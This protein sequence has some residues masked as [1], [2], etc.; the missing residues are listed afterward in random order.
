MFIFFSFLDS[1]RTAERIDFTV[2][3][4]CVRLFVPS[5]LK[6]LS[7]RKSNRKTTKE[8]FRCVSDLVVPSGRSDRFY[9]SLVVSV[10]TGKNVA[11]R[12]G[13]YGI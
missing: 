2:M 3:C 13:R 10:T 11:E 9:I 7:Y 4:V 8:L 5:V 6:R 12:F 1:E